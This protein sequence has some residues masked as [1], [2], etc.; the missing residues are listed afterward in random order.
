MK[1]IK[2]EIKR[3]VVDTHTHWEAV[4]GTVFEQKE[5]CEKYEKS[6]LGML[7]GKVNE[8]IVGEAA[9]AWDLMGGNEDSSVVAILLAKEKDADTFL[10]W[11]YLECPWLLND[12]MK[13]RKEEI[14]A[15]V[16]DV[17]T[18]KDVILMGMNCDGDYYFINSRKNIIDNLNKLYVKDERFL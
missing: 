5:E 14:E 10:Q 3:E 1:E 18:N 6:A 13:K 7:R 9:D 2:E 17:Y 4:D 16:R 8:L 12:T 11:L 15:T